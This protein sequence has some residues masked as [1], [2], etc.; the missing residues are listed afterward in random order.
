M[1][2]IG[3]VEG[4]FV[5]GVGY[6][7]TEKLIFDKGSGQLLTHNTWV[8]GNQPRPN[9]PGLAQLSMLQ[10]TAA[11]NVTLKGGRGLGMWLV[12]NSLLS[13]LLLST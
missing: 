12:Y 3:Q 5:M 8:G 7:L 9:S 13:K 10:K 1:I 6:W 4:A 11:F 2:D